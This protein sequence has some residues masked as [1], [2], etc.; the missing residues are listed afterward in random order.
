MNTTK[1]SATDRVKHT[2]ATLKHVRVVR[3]SETNEWIVRYTDA[4]KRGSDYF[5]DDVADAISTA[6]HLEQIAVN[7]EAARTISVRLAV[8]V[9]YMY[10]V[11]IGGVAQCPDQFGGQTAAQAVTQAQERFGSDYTF[12]GKLE[13]RHITGL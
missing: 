7:V 12:D 2:N 5:T 10:Q 11:K 1:P 6:R 4:A 3:K 9:G 13:R 8:G